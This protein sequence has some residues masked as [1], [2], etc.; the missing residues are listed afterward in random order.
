MLDLQAAHQRRFGAESAALASMQDLIEAGPAALALVDRLRADRATSDSCAVQ[1]IRLLAPLPRPLQMR[2]ALTFRAHLA[3]T[4]GDFTVQQQAMLD[5]FLS[6]PFWYKCNRLS[7]VGPDVDVIWPAYSQVMDYEHELAMVI[8]CRG[9]AI[10]LKD[11]PRHIF[12]YTIFNDFSA[13]D[14]QGPEMSALGPARCKDFDGGNVLGPCIVTADEFDPTNATMT[15]RINGEVVNRGN[16]G[17]MHYSFAEL[18]TFI[19]EGETLHPGE[20]ICSGTVGGGC[21]AENGRFLNSGD[22]VEL[23]IERIGS[24]RNRVLV[25]QSAANQPR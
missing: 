4:Q 5:R 19:S 22:I 3:D 20:I 21:G 24:L 12:G 15:L 18:I 7:V 23:E 1:E 13:R 11:A 10:A 9:R 2:D 17:T 6:R 25:G 16:A 14:L 8:G